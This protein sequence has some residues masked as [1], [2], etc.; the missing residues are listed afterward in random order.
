MSQ[1]GRN[2]IAI[3]GSGINTLTPD[4][5]GAVSPV[6]GNIDVHGIGGIVTSNTGA[7]S[8]TIDAPSLV[9]SSLFMPSRLV[10]TFLTA[11]LT[12][13]RLA[14]ALDA[15]SD[16]LASSC[17]AIC[18]PTTPQPSMP[19]LRVFIGEVSQTYESCRGA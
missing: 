8:L 5:G 16:L 17:S 9:R 10:L 7:G 14:P 6:L 1:A 11:T 18:E 2:N 12:S 13:S 15:K 3:G 4:V 19:T